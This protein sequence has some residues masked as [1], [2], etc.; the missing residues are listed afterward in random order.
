MKVGAH[1]QMMQQTLSQ[2][3]LTRLVDEIPQAE[4]DRM[5]TINTQA[6]AWGGMA[7]LGESSEVR[8]FSTFATARASVHFACKVPGVMAADFV[9]KD[10]LVAPGGTQVLAVYTGP[11]ASEIVVAQIDVHVE[12]PREGTCAATCVVVG[13]DGPVTS[14]DLAG[15]PAA[16]NDR[17][18]VWESGGISF[19]IAGRGL[20]REEGERIRGGM[21]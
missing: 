9:L 21:S 10:V 6:G 4:K 20:A 3:D 16:W 7:P 12:T 14:L 15:T 19:A 17:M 2:H 5:W 8:R 18:L 13:G 1:T 11:D